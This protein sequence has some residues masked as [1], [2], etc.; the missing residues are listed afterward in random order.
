MTPTKAA[1]APGSAGINTVDVVAIQRHVLTL[2]TP[3]T[4]CRLA[5][6]D[7]N[8]DTVINT[9][10]V[11]AVQR[12]AVGLSTAT[13]NVGKYQF[14]PANRAYPGVVSDQTGQNYDTLVFGDVVSPFVEP[15]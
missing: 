15:Q 3:L 5:A 10:D 4:G 7:V 6:A 14:T 13:A 1:L 8:G 11:V 12:F 2:G 9:V